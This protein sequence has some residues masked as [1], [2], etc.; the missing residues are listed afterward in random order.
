M[1]GT[2]RPVAHWR[3]ILAFVLDLLS[4]FVVIGFLVAEL[5]GGRTEGGFTLGGW[6]A[7]LLLALII[8]YFVIGGR[9]GGTIWQRVLGVQKR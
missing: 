7:I 8:A 3:I 5:F 9:N 4:S 2:D 1:S 6:R